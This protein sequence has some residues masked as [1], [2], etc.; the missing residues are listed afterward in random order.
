MSPTTSTPASE[1]QSSPS[2]NSSSISTQEATHVE[3]AKKLSMST[4]LTPEIISYFIAG[5]CA[6]AASRTVVSPLER[7]KIIQQVQPRTSDGQYKGVWRSLARMWREE[8]FKGFM[9]GSTY[10]LD[11]VRSRLSIATASIALAA[12]PTASTSSS[13]SASATLLKSSTSTASIPKHAAALF[14]TTSAIHSA[15]TAAAGAYT[16][17]DL[18]IVGMTLKIMRE[19]GGVRGLY[20]GLVTTAVGVAPYVGI[21]FAAYEFLRGIVTPPGKS[22]VWRKLSCGAL[23]GTISQTLTYPFDVL[24]RKMQVTGMKGGQ[25]KYRGAV[26]ALTSIVKAEGVAGLYRGLWPNLCE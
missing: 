15:S 22:S 7:L 8:G 4:F 1:P 17:T 23:A 5:G 12:A 3:Q 19:E 14:H 25:V 6:G 2:S 16:K 24:R 11:L 9:R 26:H 10:P 13:T 21:N 20:R 18:T